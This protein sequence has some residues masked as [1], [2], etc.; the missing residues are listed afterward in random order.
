MGRR[1]EISSLWFAV[2]E[3]IQ[4]AGR[5]ERFV[6]AYL[7]EQSLSSLVAAECIIATGFRTR[8]EAAESIRPRAASAAA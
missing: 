3:A 7:T 4:G 1:I 5:R 6:V 2:I 8:D